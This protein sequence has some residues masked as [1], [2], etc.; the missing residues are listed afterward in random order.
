MNI[1]K[2]VE[3]YNR[4]LSEWDLEKKQNDKLKELTEELKNKQTLNDFFESFSPE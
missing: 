2:N 4:S 3:M 1:E